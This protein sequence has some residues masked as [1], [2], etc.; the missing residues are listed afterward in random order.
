[1][2]RRVDL[3][4]PVHRDQ[5]VDLRGGDRRV[6]Q[7]FLDDPDVGPAVQQVRGERV[8]QRVRRYVGSGVQPGA[9]GGGVQHAPGTLPGQPAASRVQEHGRADRPA[10]GRRRESRPGAHQVRL[11]GAHRVAAHRDHPLLAALA[12]QPH[13]RVL[14][15][16]EFVDVKP[17]RLRD[18]GPGPV[19]ELQQRPV[20]EQPRVGT[21]RAGWSLRAGT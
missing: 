13:D 21:G 7:Q 15:Q 9:D 5:G 11:E 18:P 2:R 1:M 8:P 12:G 14:I 4:E 6:A 10:L 3:A 20:P 17:G 16:P 19:E